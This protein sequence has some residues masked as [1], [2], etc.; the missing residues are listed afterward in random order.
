MKRLL[1]PIVIILGLVFSLLGPINTVHANSL[2]PFPDLD[3]DGIS[4]TLEENGWYNLS[5]ILYQTDPSNADSDLDGLNDGEEKL[6]NTDPTDLESPGISVKYDSAYKTFEYYST[7][8]PA[9][10]A[11]VQGGNQYLLTEALVVRRGSTFKIAAVN[12]GTATLTISG[13]GLTALTPVPDP[14]RGGWN[15]TI[16]PNGTVGIY[17]ATIT[18]GAWS[19]SMPIYV[20]F[21]L[22]TDLTQAQ[23]NTYLYDDDPANDRDEVAVWW[24][25][26]DWKY[27]NND[28]VDPTPCLPG[29]PICSNWQYHTISAYSQAFW[30]EQYTK[31]VLVDFTLPVINGISS[32]SNATD[33]LANKADQSVR[34]NF[35]SVKNSFSSATTYFYDPSHPQ[36]PYH[37][38]GGACETQAG[39]FTSLLRSAGIPA[40][41][42]AMDYNKT[43]GHDEG[44]P[45]SDHFE[46]DHSVMMW[47]NGV[48]YAQRTFNQEEAEYASSPSWTHG[49]LSDPSLFQDW[50][51]QFKFQDYYADAVQ[52][53]NDGWDYQVGSDGGGMVNTQW[54]GIDVPGAEFVYQNRDLKWNSKRPLAIQQ[55]PFVDIFN[56]QL[57]KGD[58]W[59][60]SEWRNPP[61]SDPE[62][63]DAIH[64]YILTDNVLPDPTD[65]LENWPYNPFPTSCSFSTSQVACDA[66][67][68]AWQATC[69]PLPGQTFP[70]ILP[71]ELQPDKSKASALDPS[72]KLGKIISDA[73]Q[74]QDGDGRFD[75][76]IVEVEITSSK[77]DEYQLS[78]SLLAGEEHIRAQ[79]S[80]VALKPGLQTIRVAFDGQ[81]IGDNQADGPFEVEAIWV[82]PTD[83]AISELALPEEMAA[84]QSYS[85]LSSPYKAN[86]FT[87]RAASIDGNYTYIGK[88]LNANGLIDTITISVPLNI[89]I[90][91]TFKVESDLYDGMGRFVGHAD[92]TGRG[93]VASLEYAI[94]GTYPP[95]TLE[96]LNLM[97]TQGEELAAFYAPV[98]RINDLSGRV[99]QGNINLGSHST[100]VIPESAITPTNTFSVTPVDS[101]GNGA[102]DQLVVSAGVDVADQGGSFWMEGLLVSSH[103]VPVAWSVGIPQTLNVGLNQ[104]LQMT[105]D[106][107]MLF[108]QLPQTGTHAFT[109]TAVKIFSGSPGL[110]TLEVDVP[111]PG[112][113]TPAYSRTQF[114]PPI[115]PTL[116]QDD[117]ESGAANW[118]TT[119]LSQWS[120]IDQ[121]WRS[122]THAWI[123]NGSGTRNGTLTLATPLN[124]V[125]YG[126]PWLRFSTAYRLLNNQSV[127][128]EVS[129]DGSSWT[130]MKT[131]TGST[132]YWNTEMVDLSA[133][134]KTSGVRFR[135]NAQSN[136]GSIWYID[137]VFVYD[138]LSIRYLPLLIR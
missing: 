78:G 83:Q 17:T 114:E 137:D 72:I 23:I 96:H 60:P 19:K 30:T 88:D 87:V 99:D 57:W 41:P 61:V 62:G 25:A 125:N 102:Y 24:R 101:N 15:V 32:P 111:L 26:I 121:T 64:T 112:F 11:V 43:P 40:R 12:S 48:W 110:A 9:Y 130:T 38:A 59:A 1:T 108:D 106:G 85:Y 4:N 71:T 136:P 127:S 54:T 21:A 20:I 51:S 70:N 100:I 67:V 13:S 84:Y 10:I 75:E 124:L 33:A 56:C 66:F 46:Y 118:H 123:A 134:R 82:A 133:Y 76:L 53:A 119:G 73:G 50:R 103:G 35:Y 90:P 92:W 2:Y 105:Y 86:D 93:A 89:A 36:A 42:F 3:Q 115:T 63:R 109:L 138:W 74:D 6:F 22:P 28:S 34:V 45:S 5:G 55:S 81:L 77:A 113:N 14:A 58:I 49:H 80:T 94:A 47:L 7:T 126:N 31:K 107:R 98:Y 91:G 68:A 52:S 128:L 27:Y 120:R 79:Y 44:I 132:I 117:M 104:T 16:P 18:L 39:V 95:Y 8:D 69:S 37:M 135:F 97:D 129:T 131:Y 116:F 65:P 29:D 122:W